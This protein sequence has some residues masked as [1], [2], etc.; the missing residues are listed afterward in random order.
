VLS[1]HWPVSVEAPVRWNL[2]QYW[3]ANTPDDRRLVRALSTPGLVDEVEHAM[4]PYPDGGEETLASDRKRA[5]VAAW[6]LT[7]KKPR[8]ATIYLTSLDHYE[9]SD[10]PFSTKANETLEAIDEL[11]GELRQA[12]G[13]D[14]VFC[15]VSD[16]GFLPI[17]KETNPNVLLARAG[18][19]QT[20]PDGTVSDWQASAW[21]SAGTAAVM[22]RTPDA[23]RKARAA[24]KDLEGVGRVIEGAELKAM[25]GYPEAAFVLGAAQGYAFGNNVSG[26]VVRDS[27]SRGTH[28]YLP[29]MRDMNSSFF[30]V[31]PSLRRKGDLGQIDMR[32]IAPTLAAFLGVELPQAEGKN[33]FASW[34]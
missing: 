7:N 11:V 23:A 27:A 2:V 6:L 13:Q 31:G 22:A 15:I 9:H 30:L 1:V 20:K 14:A 19:I 26:E 16:H 21:T 34:K 8:L 29:D 4:G 32:D 25:G 17:Q 5:E 28:G 18:L 24:L 12:S 3:R 33:L 10:G